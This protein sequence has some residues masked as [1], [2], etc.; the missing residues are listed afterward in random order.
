MK[1]IVGF[2][3]YQ[4]SSSKYLADFLPSLKAALAFLNPADYRIYVWDNSSPEYGANRLVLAAD[5]QIEYE[6]QGTNL[7]FSRAYNILL[8]RAAK[9]G[10][11]YFLFL[12]PDMFLNP[13]AIEEMLKV[14][15]NNGELVSVSPKILRWDF[16]NRIKTKQIDSCGII[17]KTGLRFKDLGQ[18][19]EDHGQ[20]DQANILGPS[21]AAGLYR[22]KLLERIKEN[23]TYLDER[24]FMY[25]EDCDLNYRLF[26]AGLKS[27]LVSS[28]LIYHDRT[29]ASS[30]SGLGLVVKD[31]LKKNR[32]IREWSHLN[33]HLIYV[34]H[35]SKQNFVNKLFIIFRV[36]IVLVFSL[37]LEQF[38]LKNYRRLLR[39]L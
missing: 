15:E 16:V 39:F 10:A 29:A 5:S 13:R 22:L 34:K 12:N 9:V 14:L 3:T 7:G 37:M 36:G 30:G 8:N 38:N 18:G 28:A 4:N 33:E 17:L 25:R 35:W 24:F 21:G 20:Y 1:L 26:L 19:E 27:A 2:I 23:G 31:R 11:E 6:T 32:S